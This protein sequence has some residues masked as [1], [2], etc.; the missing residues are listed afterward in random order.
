MRS[1]L[2]ILSHILIP[3]YV[4]TC[5]TFNRSSWISW[6]E[7]RFAEQLLVTS[8]S[9]WQLQIEFH[10][11]LTSWRKVSSLLL[12]PIQ[13]NPILLGWWRVLSTSS[14]AAIHRPL[15]WETSSFSRLCRWW[16]LMASSMETTD[17]VLPVVI[18]TEDG[19]TP[20]RSYIQQF[21]ILRSSL[22]LYQTR[23]IWLCTLISMDTAEERTFSCMVTPNMTMMKLQESC[24]SW[25]RSW[26]NPIFHMITRDLT[27][28]DQKSTQP[29]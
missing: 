3:I 2:H 25:C 14:L 4:S 19:N 21:I 8:V 26:P 24:L 9:T 29:E 20:V 10:M 18:S 1:T 13:E 28:A 16:I 7:I 23:D 11:K 22:Q 12:G 15:R 17:A 6:P 5:V 27:S